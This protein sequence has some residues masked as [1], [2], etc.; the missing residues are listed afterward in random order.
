MTNKE[1]YLDSY[2]RTMCRLKSILADEPRLKDEDGW[3]VE[4]HIPRESTVKKMVHV[5]REEGV[6]DKEDMLAF[7][8]QSCMQ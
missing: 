5:M 6:M 1:K 4:G 7:I 3:N 2:L 8:M